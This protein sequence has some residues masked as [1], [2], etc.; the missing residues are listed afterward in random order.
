[1]NNDVHRF[2]GQNF[3]ECR[4]RVLMKLTALGLPKTTQ[5][6][7]SKENNAKAFDVV[8]NILD[9]VILRLVTNV[10][11]PYGSNA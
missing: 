2:T 9:D 4:I 1:M 11:E 7:T 5:D 8:I 6:N 10:R 3:L